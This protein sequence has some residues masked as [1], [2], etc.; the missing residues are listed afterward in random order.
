M[1][2]HPRFEILFF[3]FADSRKGRKAQLRM[4]I[5]TIKFLKLN[6]IFNI[7]PPFVDLEVS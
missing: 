3:G 7:F 4:L 2:L 6:Y 1:R 5:G